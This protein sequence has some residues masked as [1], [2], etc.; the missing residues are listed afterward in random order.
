MENREIRF[1]AY[2]KAKK[3]ITKLLPNSKVMYDDKNKGYYI[4]DEGTN[5]IAIKYP[6]L[7]YSKDVMS[8]YI[9]LDIAM[10]WNKIEVRNNKNFRNDKAS[11]TILDEDLVG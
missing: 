7:A 8:A 3:K 11:V 2:Q 10:H 5:I 6:D 1:R 9:N 4:S